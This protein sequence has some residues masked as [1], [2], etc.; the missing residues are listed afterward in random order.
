MRNPIGVVIFDKEQQFA[1]QQVG[2]KGESSK[3]TRGKGKT[4]Y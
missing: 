2:K 4:K 1:V 3:P